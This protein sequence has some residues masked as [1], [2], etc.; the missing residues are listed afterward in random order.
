M[1]DADN[2]GA[3][4]RSRRVASPVTSPIRRA[5]G[6]DDLSCL[7]GSGD[8]RHRMSRI[9]GYQAGRRRSV[10]NAKSGFYPKQPP[11]AGVE[12]AV[13][14][15]ASNQSGGTVGRID[16]GTSTDR[17]ANRLKPLS[18]IAVKSDGPSTG[19]LGSP[20]GSVLRVAVDRG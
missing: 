13:I 20:G 15:I 12:A 2:L 9:I 10:S 7:Q 16:H 5:D 17:A 4:V 6:G 14:E 11:L 18:C 3:T 8:E 19:G 1:N